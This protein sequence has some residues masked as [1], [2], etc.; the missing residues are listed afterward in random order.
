[1]VGVPSDCHLSLS[2]GAGKA[3]GR[4]A[5]GGCPAL[6]TPVSPRSPRHCRGSA[7]SWQRLPRR[8][9]GAAGVSGLMPLVCRG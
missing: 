3:A 1:M 8:A 7:T 2:P 6:A 5:R 9:E 4:G